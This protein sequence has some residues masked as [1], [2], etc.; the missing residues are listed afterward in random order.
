MREKSPARFSGV[1]ENTMPSIGMM[2]K[3]G[4]FSMNIVKYLN[5]KYDENDLVFFLHPLLV[6][7]RSED[8]CTKP[9]G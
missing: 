2:S 3:A 5:G 4:R 8:V 6:F 9:V 1:H 7:G